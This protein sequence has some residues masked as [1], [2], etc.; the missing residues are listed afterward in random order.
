MTT[1]Y[2]I[3]GGGE[4][5]EKAR[6]VLPILVRQAQ[7]GQ[8]T[9][10]SDL[11]RETGIDHRFGFNELLGIIG[12]T[13]KELRSAQKELGPI[14]EINAIV[15][16]KTQRI[17]GPGLAVFIRRYATPSTPKKREVAALEQSKVFDFKEWDNILRK[18]RLKPLPRN[19]PELAELRKKASEHRGGSGGEGEQ[20]KALK[21]FVLQ[22]PRK[23]EFKKVL[24][25]AK[26]ERRLPSGDSVDVFFESWGYWYGV[27]VK[28]AISSE[29]D[30]LRGIY[31]CVKYRAVMKAEAIAGGWKKEIRAVLVLEGVLPDKLIGEAHALGV[32]VIEEVRD[33]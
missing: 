33:R 25:S 3:N 22:N 20:Y 17:P 4:D 19:S 28:S 8:T 32:T 1:E 6:R 26:L 21:E 12:E 18:L 5:C 7:A 14:P 11:E 15:L 27:E 23:V 31:Q 10:Y 24:E 16:D 13:L 9:T 30:I 29:A 2:T